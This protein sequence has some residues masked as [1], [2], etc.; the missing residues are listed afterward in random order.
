MFRRKITSFKQKTQIQDAVY[1]N[2]SP[3]RFQLL[4]LENTTLNPAYEVHLMVWTL[5]HYKV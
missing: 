5:I 1:K 3:A 2:V 4:I